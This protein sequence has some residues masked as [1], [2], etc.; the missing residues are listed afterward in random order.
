MKERVIEEYYEGAGTW[1]CAPLNDDYYQYRNQITNIILENKVNVPSTVPEDKQWDMS[2]AGN[3]S[4]M[5][6]LEEDSTS[7]SENVSYRLHIQGQGGVIANPNSAALFYGFPNLASISGF[8]YLD[9]SNAKFIYELDSGNSAFSIFGNCPKLNLDLSDLDASNVTNMSFMFQGYNG[10]GL[11]IGNW[12]TSNVTDMSHMFSDYSGGLLTIGDWNTSNVTTMSYMF[13]FYS[14]DQPLDLSSLDTSK[15]TDMSD[16]F[17]SY[18]SDQPLDLSSFDTSNVTDMSWMFNFYEG[19]ALTIGNWNTPNLTDMSYT[20]ENYSGGLLT[21]GDWN[22][23]NVTDMSHMFSNYSGG[24]LTIGNWNTSSVIDMSYMFDNYKGPNLVIGNWDTSSIV[25]MESMFF[26]YHADHLDMSS[27]EFPTSANLK[28][29]FTNRNG[30]THQY[31][32][33]VKDE[34][35]KAFLV[36]LR[37]NL[38]YWPTIEVAS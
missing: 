26:D 20:F 31:T 37:S 34:K 21:I 6:Y 22:I 30:N 17:S 16:M 36:D 38:T 4:V 14:G 19:G 33:T 24:L 11:T 1:A 18:S 35:T 25:T 9:I 28:Y 12:N 15:V 13:S 2:A 3:S 27:F 29:L 10:E 7:D 5:A 23:P 8:Q 32:L